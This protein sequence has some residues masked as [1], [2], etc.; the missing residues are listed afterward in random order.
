[1]SRSRFY[2]TAD[3][4][5]KKLYATDDKYAVFRIRL[6]TQQGQGLDYFRRQ[7]AAGGGLAGR[8]P[9]GVYSDGNK[10]GLIGE[11]QREF[12][13]YPHPVDE[14]SFKPRETG[15]FPPVWTASWS[16]DGQKIMT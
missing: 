15:H 13:A 6:A 4:F 7:V 16:P 5:A 11:L 10:D 2:L 9:G 3:R 12:I 8:V 14:Y 1:M